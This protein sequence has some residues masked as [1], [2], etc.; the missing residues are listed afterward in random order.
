MLLRISPLMRLSSSGK[1]I[2][3]VSDE[4]GELHVH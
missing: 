4:Q 1:L 2:V 3:V